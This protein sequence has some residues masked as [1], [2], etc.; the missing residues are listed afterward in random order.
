[1]LPS[2]AGNC[3][4]LYWRDVGEVSGSHRLAFRL[5]PRNTYGHI[6]SHRQCLQGMNSTR[7]MRQSFLYNCPTNTSC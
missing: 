4:A 7:Y 2:T 6:T 1:M 5:L 3:L